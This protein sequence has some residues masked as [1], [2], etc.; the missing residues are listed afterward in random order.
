MDTDTVPPHEASLTVNEQVI[1]MSG[2]ETIRVLEVGVD[3]PVPVEN[4]GKTLKT[5]SATREEA[6]VSC[7]PEPSEMGREGV[8]QNP[9]KASGESGGEVKALPEITPAPIPGIVPFSQVTSQQTQTLTPVT[10]QAAPQYCRSSGKSAGAGCVDISCSNGC[11]PPRTD[12]CLYYWG[13][14]QITYSQFASCRSA[15]HGN[16]S[17]FAASPASPGAANSPTAATSPNT[18]CVPAS[19]SAS[20]FATAGRSIHTTCRQALGNANP[21]HSSA[22]RICL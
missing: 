11:C 6:P 22:S 20:H 16:T 21:D 5:A 19:G 13:N 18:D 4:E 12:G 8:E 17:P 9:T 14:F 10:L 7:P 15:E 1:V 3:A 2:H